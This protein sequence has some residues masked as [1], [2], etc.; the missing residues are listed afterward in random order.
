M[1]K[2]LARVF[3]DLL[4]FVLMT[5]CA[6]P[7]MAADTPAVIRE[8]EH[9]GQ[10]I[11]VTVDQ[12][13]QQFV[14]IDYAGS[15]YVWDA[16]SMR[17]ISTSRRVP[18]SVRAATFLEGRKLAVAGTGQQDFLAIVDLDD[19]GAPRV[20]G[21]MGGETLAFSKKLPN[22]NFRAAVATPNSVKIA[23]FNY[24]GIVREVYRSDAPGLSAIAISDDGKELAFA[25]QKSEATLVDVDTGKVAWHRQTDAPLTS[26]GVSRETS[27][28]VGG[29][30]STIA[31]KLKRI[32]QFNLRSG[33]TIR[34]IPAAPCSV[35][36]VAVIDTD[37]ALAI[38]GSS[39]A[40]GLIKLGEKPPTVFMTWTLSDARSHIEVDSVP[41]ANVTYLPFAAGI[42]YA[43]K[44]QTAFVGGGD[45]SMFADTF[46]TRSRPG[47]IVRLAPI[48]QLTS[49][50]LIAPDGNRVFA[51]SPVFGRN[52][53]IDNKV[54]L[55]RDDVIAAL[56]KATGEGK[57]SDDE[58][59]EAFSS[60]ELA[61]TPNRLTSWDVA[62]AF[63]VG[64]VNSQLGSFQD[65]ATDGGSATAVE[66]VTLPGG[67]PIEPTIFAV[68]RIS[69]EDGNLTNRK[70]LSI[71]SSS[72][73][74]KEGVKLSVD[75]PHHFELSSACYFQSLSG[76]VRISADAHVLAAY[77]PV[78]SLS[79]TPSGAHTT[80]LSFDL[81]TYPLVSGSSVSPA[82]VH[83]GGSPEQFELS[84]D[85]SAVAVLLETRPGD[86][87][88]PDDHGDHAL[89]VLD[90]THAKV[91]RTLDG[92]PQSSTGS[93]VTF[94]ADGNQLYF[95][96]GAEVRRYDIKADRLDHLRLD[97]SAPDVLVTALAVSDSGNA[98]AVSRQR[99][100]TEV[101]DL[102][103][104]KRT[105][106]FQHPG[107]TA[108]QVEFD[109]Q[110]ENR[111]FVSMG[112]GGIALL[113]D[114]TG[115]RITDFLSYESGDWIVTAPGGVFS[116]SVGGEGGVTVSDGRRAVGV[117]QLYDLYFRPDLLRQRIATDAEATVSPDLLRRALTKPPPEIDARIVSSSPD[118]T[119][120][121]VAVRDTGG[122][123][124]GLRVFHNGKLA[125][126]MNGEQ[127]A[128]A[129]K[130]AGRMG[131][132]SF[133]I[134]C[135]LPVAT[136]NNDYLFAGISGDGSLQSR[137]TKLSTY[138]APPPPRPRRGYVL[139]I[140]TNT[141][142]RAPFPGLK[143]AETSATKVGEAFAKIFSSLAGPENVVLMNLVGEGAQSGAVEEALK[144]I[145]KE[146]RPD[147][148]VAIVIATHGKVL[149]SGE[150][151][152]ALRDTEANGDRALTATRLIDAMNRSQALTQ[153]LVLDICHAGVV[154]DRVASVYQERFAVFSGRA[155]IHVL[156]ATSAEEP[157]LAGYKG[158]TA[159]SHFL[160]EGLSS[161]PGDGA[162]QHSL[163]TIANGTA[164]QV[165]AAAK[166]FQFNQVPSIYSFGSDL[167]FP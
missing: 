143:L 29:Y 106:V 54:L 63:N 9:N 15:I 94:S 59:K 56:S 103:D 43:R 22:G 17:Q 134:K 162:T 140:G 69:M 165:T 6:L 61:V 92:L 41:G 45:G 51:I 2:R 113:D 87:Q 123:I 44:T 131:S 130:S 31:G 76:N 104:G 149:E 129:A 5:A 82:R 91:I 167:R 23:E 114:T 16:A 42:G 159:F 108:A 127:L 81:L 107:E 28:I 125:I 58:L 68:S 53:R 64:A 150:M 79:I 86:I 37:R 67:P 49:R 136:G 154:P 119:E 84:R 100:M 101:F 138:R 80:R 36:Q 77:C 38:C 110:R 97:S 8:R 62:N 47:R 146:T 158:T 65:V 93:T 74:L 148:L 121:S 48:P 25:T 137:F 89:V 128:R 117:D 166:Q 40:D 78:G 163:R 120:A 46:E 96:A 109:R 1:H 95:A 160:L 70:L 20:I 112:T 156:A 155:G 83:L 98:L 139:M 124:G 21:R 50:F 32:D 66:V 141:F 24:S 10:V 85:G 133:S 122:G 153:V 19:A 152:V 132:D 115:E 52:G 157:A 72:G 27:V 3:N 90:T 73:L 14:S 30:D 33:A 144:R 102:H 116:A 142:T 105:H 88:K 135:S 111:L 161:S 13:N 4:V 75:E 26:L 12:D 18:F 35:F 147:D 126:N 55:H 60:P 39:I 164:Q 99:G 145:E 7:A 71:D 118:R 34:E 11:F 57:A 151:M